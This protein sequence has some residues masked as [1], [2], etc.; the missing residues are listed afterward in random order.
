MTY[1]VVTGNPVDGFEYYGPFISYE[2][3]LRFAEAQFKHDVWWI[4]DLNPPST[5]GDDDDAAEEEANDDE[6]PEAA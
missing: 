4:P 6:P 1:L 5:F 2:S 3:A